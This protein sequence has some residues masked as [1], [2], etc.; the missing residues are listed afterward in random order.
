MTE[1][2]KTETAPSVGNASEDNAEADTIERPAA[3]T[4]ASGR[5]SEAGASEKGD[6]TE[7]AAADSSQPPTI[8]QPALEQHDNSVIIRRGDTLW[9]ISRRIYG[10]GVR[11]TTIYLAN[12]DQIKNPDFIEPGQTFMVPAEPLENA[13][14][15]HRQRILGHQ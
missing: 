5:P 12:T 11:Y 13:E 6:M 14:Q 4:A 1:T 8:V 9:Q 2:A 15:L 7:T 3:E 10:R